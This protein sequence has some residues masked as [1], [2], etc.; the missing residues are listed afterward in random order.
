MLV[1]VVVLRFGVAD[2]QDPTAIANG[3]AGLFG[4][5]GFMLCG[6]ALVRLG[7]LGRRGDVAVD[8]GD[9]IIAATGTTDP[10]V[11]RRVEFVQRLFGIGL[12]LGACGV[13]LFGVAVATAGGTVAAAALLF[14][15]VALLL[16][17][18][19]R[20]RG[21]RGIDTS[22]WARY[23]TQRPPA[24]QS[25]LPDEAPSPDPPAEQHP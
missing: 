9:R 21:G 10:Q 1:G 11:V 8:R 3:A 22:S 15:C 19:H 6:V 23:W 2:S 16:S 12:L 24:S 4:G 13:G 18:V 20:L 5:C 25:P 17:S 14:G 7:V